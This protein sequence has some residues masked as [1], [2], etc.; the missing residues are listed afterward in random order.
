M[1]EDPMGFLDQSHYDIVLIQETK[2][3]D[4]SEYTTPTWICVGSGTTAQKHAGVMILIRRSITNAHEVRHDAVNPRSLATRALPAG[5]N[6][7]P[8]QC[9]LCIPTRMEPERH[10]HIGKKK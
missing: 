1:Y 7:P 9:D 8:A 3:R 6:W 5:S 10:S 2:L 4:D